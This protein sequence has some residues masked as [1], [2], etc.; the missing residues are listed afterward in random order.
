MIIK[1]IIYNIKFIKAETEWIILTLKQTG[2]LLI[3]SHKKKDS[4]T[5]M[6]SRTDKFESSRIYKFEEIV[7][8]I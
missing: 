4:M 1:M 5:K 3:F 2:I 8:K 6:I 7:K